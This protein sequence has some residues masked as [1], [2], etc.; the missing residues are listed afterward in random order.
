MKLAEELR[1]KMPTLSGEARLYQAAVDALRSHNPSATAMMCK[2]AAADRAMLLALV[3]HYL[4]IVRA[5]MQRP[6]LK[7]DGAA[8]Q[9]IGVT[10]VKHAPAPSTSLPGE[11]RTTFEAQ[12]LNAQPRQSYDEGEGQVRSDPRSMGAFPSSTELHG[13]GQ[14]KHEAQSWSARSMQ[15]NDSSGGHRNVDTQNLRAPAA[16]AIPTPKRD[17][18]AMA[19]IQGIMAK[20][21][22]FRLQDG[23]N[24]MD[25]AFHE[26]VKIKRNGIKHATA[27]AR[28]S[29]VADYLLQHCSY[30]NPDPH[31]KV[32]AYFPPKMIELAIAEADKK[33][34]AH[35]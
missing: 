15:P 18:S 24:I 2:V 30:A 34:A 25:V 32:G 14:G 26:L 3:E 20:S 31:E 5:D 11:G 21:I 28:E 22:T 27:F 19:A 9:M 35:V 10:L 8:S 23:R 4:R 1:N 33:E 12:F 6:A 13:E 7:T 17:A 29:I 16:A